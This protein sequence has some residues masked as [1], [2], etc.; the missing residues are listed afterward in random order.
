[1]RRVSESLLPLPSFPSFLLLQLQCEHT[2]I[3]VSTADAAAAQSLAAAKKTP[4]GKRTASVARLADASVATLDREGGGEG[5]EVKSEGC[6][7]VEAGTYVF[8]EMELDRPLIPKR[9]PS[10]LAQR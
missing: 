7:Y 4:G 10:I 8:L 6:A 9:R 5:G 3:L 1:M 2:S